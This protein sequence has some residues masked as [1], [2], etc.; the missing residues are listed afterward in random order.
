MP[1]CVPIKDMKD[2]ARFARI[3]E[4][5]EGPVTVTKNGYH[6]FVVMR[7]ADYDRLVKDRDEAAKQRLLERIAIAE[8]EIEEGRFEDYG[9]ATS[10]LRAEYGL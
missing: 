3:V 7:S 1:I 10:A 5:A 9:K 8:R 2:T 4:E 6:A